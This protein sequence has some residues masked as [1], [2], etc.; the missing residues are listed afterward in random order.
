MAVKRALD[1]VGAKQL[2]TRNR[3]GGGKRAE[4]AKEKNH[5]TGLRLVETARAMKGRR[6][7][8][9]ITGEPSKGA[10]P[11][12]GSFENALPAKNCRGR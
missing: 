3:R 4:R 11:G 5:R 2:P 1:A 6:R 12:E 10:A 7:R 8:E 9:G